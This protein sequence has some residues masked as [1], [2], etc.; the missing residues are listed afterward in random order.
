MSELPKGPFVLWIYYGS[1]GWAFRDHD[2]FEAAVTDVGYCG[3]SAWTITQGPLV[4][5]WRQPD[6]KDTPT[7]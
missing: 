1:E 6:P 4:I 3:A 7:P 5:E 2:T